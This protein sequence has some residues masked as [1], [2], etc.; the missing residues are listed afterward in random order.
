MTTILLLAA[1]LTPRIFSADYCADQ[2]ALA[3]AT[4]GEIAALSPEATGP[5]SHLAAEARA[6]PRRRPT[7]ENVVASRA[8]IVLRTFGGDAA[9][10]KRSGA[11]VITLNDASDFEGIR[12]TIRTAAAALNARNKGEALIAQMDAKLA[13]L[14]MKPKLA[15][16]GLYVTPG[17]VTAGKGTI[18]DAIFDA[19]RVPNLAAAAGLSYWPPLPLEAIALRPPKLAVEGFFDR[20]LAGADNWSAA[21]HPA[22]AKSL[23][24]VKIVRLSADVLS[25][26]AWFAADAAVELRAQAEYA[27]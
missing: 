24:G 26:P 17:G 12:K 13:A 16:S 3:L 19:A 5:Y 14:V 9:G 2:Y 4:P 18:V 21:Q 11:K 15:V 23:A 8:D 6:F 22:Y 20:R 25:C 1:L 10:L 7:L 27:Q